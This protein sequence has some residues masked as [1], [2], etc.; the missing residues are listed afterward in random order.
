MRLIGGF[1]FRLPWGRCQSYMW[2]HSG[3]WVFRCS[4][5]RQ[6]RAQA[7]PDIAFLTRQA[8]HQ[9][10]GARPVDQQALLLLDRQLTFLRLVD[11]QG[12]PGLQIGGTV[13]RAGKPAIAT[14]AAARLIWIAP[15]DSPEWLE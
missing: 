13:S 7:H 10:L 3:R 15:R 9:R 11:C 5:V 2:V 8:E 6:A 1:E 12:S 14:R 4:E